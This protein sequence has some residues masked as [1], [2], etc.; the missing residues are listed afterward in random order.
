M[1]NFNELWLFTKPIA[2]RGLAELNGYLENTLPAFINSADKGYPIETD[3]RLCADGEIVCF[4][5]DNLN[6]LANIDKKIIDLT[7][8][9]LEEIVLEKEQKIC[10]FKQMLQTVNGKVPLLIELKDGQDKILV[11]KTL[12]LLKNYSGEYAF[13]SFDPRLL[14]RLKKL[15]P[16]ALRGQLIVGNKRHPKLDKA[17]WD[18]INLRAKP[19]FIDHCIDNLV[20]PYKHTICWTVRKSEQLE[21]AKRLNVNITFEDETLLK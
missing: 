4:H 3:L 21:K 16:S 9:Q 10:F 1:K 19:H 15:A 6:R 18:I 13:I 8:R 5:D 7:S 2:H 14:Y 12:E 11:D 17:K 20:Y